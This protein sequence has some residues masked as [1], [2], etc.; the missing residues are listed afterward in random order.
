MKFLR[1]SQSSAPC[2]VRKAAEA[3]VERGRARDTTAP[4]LALTPLNI[5]GI[6]STASGRSVTPKACKINP[7]IFIVHNLKSNQM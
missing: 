5:N 6:I 3:A 2:K 7:K 4:L 1:I